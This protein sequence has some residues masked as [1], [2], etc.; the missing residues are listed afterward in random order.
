MMSKILQTALI[1]LL[2]QVIALAQEKTAPKYSA[3]VD[4][5]LF[6]YAVTI[7]RRHAENQI[8]CEER[9]LRVIGNFGAV[10]GVQRNVSRAGEYSRYGSFGFECFA[11]LLGHVQSQVFFQTAALN[12]ASPM[13]ISTM[14]RIEHYRSLHIGSR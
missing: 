4:C 6:C 2:L 9:W 1:L 14:A 8:A 11:E 10:P 3:R 5:R 13:V 12:T 7:R